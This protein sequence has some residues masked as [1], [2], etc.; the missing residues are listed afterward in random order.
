MRARTRP[1]LVK[2]ALLDGRTFWEPAGFHGFL[3]QWLLAVR[4]THPLCMMYRSHRL[5]PLSSCERRMEGIFQLLAGFVGMCAALAKL[6][7]KFVVARS[8]CW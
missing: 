5:S 6:G 1:G 8:Q 3:Q 2:E 7:L 4:N